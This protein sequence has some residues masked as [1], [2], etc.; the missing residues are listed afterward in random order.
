MIVALACGEDVTES[1]ITADIQFGSVNDPKIV[2]ASLMRNVA[3]AALGSLRGAAATTAFPTSGA[4]PEEEP[5]ISAK[6]RSFHTPR[7]TLTRNVEAK[8]AVLAAAAAP[9]NLSATV[10]AAFAVT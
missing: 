9:S 1:G 5:K 10:V 6:R 8:V 2:T 3:V 7:G 4:A